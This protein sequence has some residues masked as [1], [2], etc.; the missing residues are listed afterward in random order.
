MRYNWLRDLRREAVYIHFWESEKSYHLNL[1][2]KD[3]RNSTQCDQGK[4]TPDKGNI[5]SQD[6]SIGG[7][8]ES[9]HLAGT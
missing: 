1:C 3:G 9:S 5:L 2:L 4:G 8:R 6:M 7:S